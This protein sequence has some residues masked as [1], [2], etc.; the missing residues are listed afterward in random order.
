MTPA[1]YRKGG[2]GMNIQ[3][4][5]V[6]C[7]LGRLLV[8]ATERGICAVSL[9]DSDAALEATIQQ[10]YPAAQ[11]QR[12]ESAL[13]AWISAFLSYLHGQQPDLNLPI[14]VQAT[15]FQWRVWKILQAIP[16]GST[17]SYS[18]V[19]QA[20]GNVKARRA[21]ARACA[22]NPVALAIPC[23]RIVREDGHLG[24]YRWGLE[25][26]RLLLAQEKAISESTPAS[27]I[28]PEGEAIK[29]QAA[30]HNQEGVS[31]LS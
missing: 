18:E 22:T 29:G 17:R 7:P 24:G 31:P 13:G 3:Y 5:I 15:A 14:D 23:H 9:G 8:A 25:R 4:T 6:D 12:D 2:R 11:I 20:L 19:A 1:T 21:V 30:K 26:K 28:L 16:A 10:E 27:G